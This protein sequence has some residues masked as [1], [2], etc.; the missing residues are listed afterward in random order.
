[1]KQ[2]KIKAWVTKYALTS[3]IMLVDGVVNHGINS[4]LLKYGNYN[5][6]LPPDW[7]RTKEAALER[8]EAMRKAKIAA[9]K[10]SL[11]KLERLTFEVPD[12]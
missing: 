3:G 11:N 8:A 1:M 4:E 6:V 5:A 7:H 9:L 12:E 10:K 2:E